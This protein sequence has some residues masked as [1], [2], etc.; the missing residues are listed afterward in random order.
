MDS[1]EQI[2]KQYARTVYG[3]LLSRTG[4]P[5]L[6]EELTQETFYR[7]IKASKTY[8][9]EGSVSTWLCGIA[10]RVWYEYVRRQKQEGPLEEAGEV[11]ASSVEEEL[12]SKWESMEVL[13][14]LHNLN[15]PMR[16]VMY[17]RLAG[18]LSFAQIGEILDKSE[19]WAR[20]TFYRGKEKLLKEI[21][22]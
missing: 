19:N 14:A 7:A 11:P 8:R 4:T 17:L 3:F 10:K 12:L 1:M 21:S 20:V 9:G 2:Y 16:E 5:H 6:A 18:N 15:D 13:K 22:K